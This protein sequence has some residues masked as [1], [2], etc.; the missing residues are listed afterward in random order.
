MILL[1]TVH[2]PQ[3]H[4]SSNITEASANAGTKLKETWQL[5]LKETLV[6]SRTNT[7]TICDIPENENP[8]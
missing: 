5:S 3:L 4:L 6:Q 8:P 7:G 2:C 1:I